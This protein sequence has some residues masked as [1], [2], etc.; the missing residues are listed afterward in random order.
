[1][2]EL[3]EKDLSKGRRLKLA[4][5]G[6]P[7]ALMLVPAL[8]TLLLMLIAASGPPAAAVAAAG[9]A[10]SWQGLAETVAAPPV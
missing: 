5:I 10:E 2:Y 4:A 3:T 1:M 7:F 8:I 6:S 9:A